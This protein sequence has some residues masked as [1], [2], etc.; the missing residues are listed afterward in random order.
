MGYLRV[1]WGEGRV[2]DCRIVDGSE[3]VDATY[4]LGADYGD[5]KALQQGYDALR[6]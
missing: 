2:T 1:V 3:R 6:R 4:V 5:W